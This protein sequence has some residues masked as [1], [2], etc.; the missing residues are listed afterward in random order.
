MGISLR[1]LPRR[2]MK[3]FV[4]ACV[5]IAAV[6]AEPDAKADPYTFY[7]GLHFPSTYSSVVRPSFGLTYPTFNTYTS[8]VYNPFVHSIGKRDA[9]PKADADAAFYRSVYH[10][11][12]YGFPGYTGYSGLTCPTYSPYAAG[13]YSPFVHSIGKREAEPAADADADAALYRSVYS[14]TTYTF[15]GYTGYTAYTGYSGLTYPTYS[16]YTPGVYRPFVHSIGKRE[17]EP[18]ADADA[19]LYHSVYSPTTYTFPGY[20]GYTAPRVYSNLF[21]NFYHHY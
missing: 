20:T 19:A 21:N 11:T 5:A 10:P 17:A 7:N 15:P 6:S 8:G 3:A 13:V 14:P 18:A 4:L 12:T 16:P 1:R 9:E 2:T